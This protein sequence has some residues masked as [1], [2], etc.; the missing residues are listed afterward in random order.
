M[1]KVL[2]GLVKEPTFEE[3]I[4]SDTYD[5]SDDI[6]IYSSAALNYRQSFFAPPLGQADHGTI[7]LRG[8]YKIILEGAR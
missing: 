6:H 5:F 2:R 3:L 7:L 8:L 1:T 4:N